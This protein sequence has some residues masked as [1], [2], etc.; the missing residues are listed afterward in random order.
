MKL[1][2]WCRL[3]WFASRTH[4]SFVDVLFAEKVQN[5][6]CMKVPE[7]FHQLKISGQQPQTIEFT[8]AFTAIMF[9]NENVRDVL[10]LEDMVAEM[11][12]K[13]T[14]HNDKISN[15]HVTRFHSRQPPAITIPSYL[16]RIIQYTTLEKACLLIILI[17][18]DRISSHNPQFI[19]SSLTVHRFLI[20]A[21]TVISKLLCDA[22]CTNS[23]YARV[24]GIST[25]ELNTL[26]LEFL[27]L[28]DW[29]LYIDYS[30]L[31]K[32]YVH[33]VGCSEGILSILLHS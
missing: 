24:G 33:L 25:Q 28:I 23:H 19:L 32:Y 4:G 13:I 21:V 26:E 29:N 7:K 15:T 11:L 27:F 1:W 17:Y 10:V 6:N 20:A 30:T 16:K 5:K 12:S 3:F 31:S 18:I 14:E 8:L 9:N 2:L 22:Y